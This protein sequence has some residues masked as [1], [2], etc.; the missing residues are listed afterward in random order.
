MQ[1]RQ[2]EE[3]AIASVN[4]EIQHVVVEA[5]GTLPG[6]SCMISQET[7]KEPYCKGLLNSLGKAGQDSR[8]HSWKSSIIVISR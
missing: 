4:G 1:V 3:A 7:P 8:R 2:E 5:I 6:T